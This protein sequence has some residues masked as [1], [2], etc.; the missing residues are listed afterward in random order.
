MVGFDRLTLGR[1][2]WVVSFDTHF[3]NF[4]VKCVHLLHDM[5]FRSPSGACLSAW[6]RP[7]ARK[8]SPKRS[9]KLEN[10][11]PAEYRSWLN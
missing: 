9:Q 10:S 3:S 5:I 2:T 7:K 1:S 8:G 4:E 11:L 6:T